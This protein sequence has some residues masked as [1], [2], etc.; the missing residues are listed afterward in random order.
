MVCYCCGL[1]VSSNALSLN[2]LTINIQEIKSN[3]PGLTVYTANFLNKEIRGKYDEICDKHSA[4]CLEAH[5][6]P[7]AP[8]HVSQVSG[9]F[10]IYVVHLEGLNGDGW[11]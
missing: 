7:N 6:Y 11:D 4:I 3:Q 5:N 9:V 1:I 8:H 2:A 10:I